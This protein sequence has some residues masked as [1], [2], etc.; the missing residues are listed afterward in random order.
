M[1]ELSM[2]TS[3]TSPQPTHS[4]LVCR[5]RRCQGQSGRRHASPTAGEVELV[6]AGTIPIDL[7]L[8]M[9]PLQ[10]LDLLVKDGN[11]CVVSGWF[12]GA[13][14]SP[15]EAAYTLRLEPGQS[16][17]GPVHLLGNVPPE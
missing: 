5:L 1:P 2:R 17:V 8:Q 6:N 10:H 11:G 12:Y 7:E 4:P 3:D 15:L 16:Y 9:S 14:F 13:M